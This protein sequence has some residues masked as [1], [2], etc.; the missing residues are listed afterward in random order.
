MVNPINVLRLLQ[1]KYSARDYPN[2]P[3]IYEE[4]DLASKLFD[5]IEGYPN[6]SLTIETTVDM[7]IDDNW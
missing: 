1:Q 4:E 6:S 3:V 2:S 7:E 5:V